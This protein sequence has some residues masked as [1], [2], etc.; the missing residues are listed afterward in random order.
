MVENVTLMI[1]RALW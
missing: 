1:C